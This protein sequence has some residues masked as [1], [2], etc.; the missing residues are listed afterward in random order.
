MSCSAFFGWSYQREEESIC[1]NMERK[2]S[3]NLFGKPTDTSTARVENV[4]SPS[5]QSN[6]ITID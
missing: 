4:I 1:Q 3:G 2:C 5:Y 6:A